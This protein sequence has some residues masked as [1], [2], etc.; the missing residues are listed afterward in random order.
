MRRLAS[1]RLIGAAR[2]VSPLD[3]GGG[4]NEVWR[5]EAEIVSSLRITG[6]DHLVLR[7]ADVEKTLAFYVDALGLAPVRVDEWRR[8]TVPFRQCA[9]APGR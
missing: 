1:G 8:G 4:E 6:F 9:S 2:I 5:D 7:C 3:E